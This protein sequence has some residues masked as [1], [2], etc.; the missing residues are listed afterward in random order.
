MKILVFT[1][2]TV[3]I[4]KSWVGIPREEIVKQVKSVFSLPREEVEKLVRNGSVPWLED[5]AGF[6]PHGDSVKKIGS[7]KKQGATIV[8]LTS[9]TKP[10]EVQTI[11][12]VLRKYH[13]PQGELLSREPDEEYKDVAERVVPD[14]IV[15]D[16]CESIGEEEEM[17]CLRIRPELKARIKSVVVKDSEGID[18]LPDDIS[19]LLA[20]SRF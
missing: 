11:R 17:T 12:E 19:K 4:H 3:L 13:F 15:E 5:W 8:Y 14:I 6:V 10:E 2:G 7:W 18:H 1:E 9:R 16:D 20:Y